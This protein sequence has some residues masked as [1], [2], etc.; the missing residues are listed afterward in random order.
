MYRKYWKTNVMCSSTYMNSLKKWAA[1]LLRKKTKKHIKKHRNHRENK[2]MCVNSHFVI[3]ILV[4]VQSFKKIKRSLFITLHSIVCT[5]VQ[6]AERW[7]V[8]NIDENKNL[9][10]SDS[11]QNPWKK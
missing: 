1:S 9:A 10:Y 5:E 3:V 11:A 6:R 7:N 8:K 4:H 2:G